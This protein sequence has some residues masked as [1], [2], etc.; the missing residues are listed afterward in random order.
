VDDHPRHA[1]LKRAVPTRL[2]Q[3]FAKLHVEVNEEKSKTVELGRGE[4]F[5]F[6]G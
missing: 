6:L 3:E 4:S 1:W 2:R 5:C